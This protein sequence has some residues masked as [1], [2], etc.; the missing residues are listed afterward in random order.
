MA[1]W[2]VQSKIGKAGQRLYRYACTC[3]HHGRWLADGNGADGD[4][5][6]YR[7]HPDR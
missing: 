3:G 5:H 7:A 1:T 6:L 4:E 2:S